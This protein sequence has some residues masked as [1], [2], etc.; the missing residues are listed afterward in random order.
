[1]PNLMSVKGLATKY[2]PHE[3]HVFYY[4]HLVGI[5]DA[6]TNDSAPFKTYLKPSISPSGIDKFANS[7]NLTVA[8]SSVYDVSDYS[9]WFLKES[10]FS[11][12]SRSLYLAL[13]SFAKFISFGALGGS[14]FLVVLRR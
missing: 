10:A 5:K 13:F 6:G 1:M 12:I 9:A 11:R 7:K 8:Y 4:R 2:S 14:D 3:A